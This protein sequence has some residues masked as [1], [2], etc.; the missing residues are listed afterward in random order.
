MP[1][2]KALHF[3]VAEKKNFEDGFFVPLFELV[4]P[5]AGQFWPHEH[6]MNKL[7]RDSQG[8]AK[9]QI[10]KLYSFREEF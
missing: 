7:S 10:S 2:I 3:P 4:T 5:G 6:H 1:N 8:D 9:N